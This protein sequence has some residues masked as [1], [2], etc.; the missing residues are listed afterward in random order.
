MESAKIYN[1]ILIINYLMQCFFCL[2]FSLS[3]KS[4][5]ITLVSILCLQV[6]LEEKWKLSFFSQNCFLFCMFHKK[7]IC[8]DV[9][10][11][12]LTMLL[13]TYDDDCYGTFWAIRL[14]CYGT[15]WAN[16]LKSI[17]VLKP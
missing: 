14:F 3:E 1:L 2:N 6:L 10:S 16:R 15:F 11:D 5:I 7:N 9:Y 4:K 13:V 8:L 17:L 12:P